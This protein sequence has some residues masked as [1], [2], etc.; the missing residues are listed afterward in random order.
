MTIKEMDDVIQ[1]YCGNCNL[2]AIHPLCIFVKGDFEANEDICRAAYKIIM[3]LQKTQPD[4]VI[5][6][7]ACKG[8]KHD[9]KEQGE[10]PCRRCR[11][12]LQASNPLYKLCPDLYE[13]KKSPDN[14]YWERINAIAERQRAK[15]INKYGVGLESNPAAIM[16]RINHLQEELIDGLMYCEWI[17]DHLSELE[18]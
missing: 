3:D 13:P 8:C 10:L 18:G 16:E 2:C 5:E 12:T 4:T 9:F 15:G 14:T 17:K 7:D 1:D 11:Y 6:H